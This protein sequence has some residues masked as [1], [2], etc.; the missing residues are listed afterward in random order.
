MSE[1][2]Y[3]CVCGNA[4]NVNT[5]SCSACGHTYLSEM[6][7]K[8]IYLVDDV[9]SVTSKYEV[10]NTHSR[11]IKRSPRT[12]FRKISKGFFLGRNT[13]I[14]ANLAY[15]QKTFTD[16]SKI[17]IIGG[18]TVGEGL[19]VFYAENK[20]FITSIDLYNSDHVDC[21][22]DAHHLFFEDD[23]FDL[24]IVQAVLEHVVFPEKVISEIHRVLKN[25]KG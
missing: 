6:I 19:E 11:E 8:P 3:R 25:R 1:I 23:Q 10:E 16:N 24:V 5:A 7:G 12:N 17:L 22:M 20:R 13:S 4:V 14:E 9:Y 18:G 21:I 15:C 2:R